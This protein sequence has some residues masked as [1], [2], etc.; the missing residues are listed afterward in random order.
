MIGETE[1]NAEM[2]AA[3]KRQGMKCMHVRETENPGVFDLLIY[4]DTWL[5]AWAELKM[6]DNKL[7]ASQEEFAKYH[8]STAA[9]IRFELAGPNPRGGYL[10][11]LSRYP[12]TKSAR[13]LRAFR[14][15]DWKLAINHVQ[16]LSAL[17][18]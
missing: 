11:T 6:S 15:E 17:C 14:A 5:I 7:E 16:W 9:L 13:V 3:L 12:F 8:Q 18:T 1:F 10:L 2:R 4:K